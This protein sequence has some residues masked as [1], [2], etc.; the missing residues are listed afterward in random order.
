MERSEEDENES[1]SSQQTST[2]W[3]QFQARA[4]PLLSPKLGSRDPEDKKDRGMWMFKRMKR[5]EHV[6]LDRVISSSQPDLLFSSQAEEAPLCG[7]GAAGSGSGSGRE[8]PPASS[9]KPTVA[10]LVQS[11]HKSSSLGSACLERLAEP[12]GGGSGGG[13]GG[14]EAATAAAAAEPQLENRED[15]P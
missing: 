6:V 2:M 5:K 1:S 13:G 7:R 10:Y 9:K 4:K 8:R 12:P 15:Q 3:K 14:G 11:H